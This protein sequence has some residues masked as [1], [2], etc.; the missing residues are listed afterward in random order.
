MRL[1]KMQPSAPRNRTH[2]RLKF[3][4]YRSIERMEKFAISGVQRAV[5]TGETEQRAIR[6]GD[7]FFD[8]PP[9]STNI[10]NIAGGKRRRIVFGHAA[11]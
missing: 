9:V 8:K 4:F 5:D 2:L 7:G 1:Q 11:S 6:P 3:L 10:D